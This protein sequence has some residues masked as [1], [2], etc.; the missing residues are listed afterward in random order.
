MPGGHSIPRAGS[1][2]SS[3]K[4]H[5]LGE[6][7]WRR[8]SSTHDIATLAEKG[9]VRDVGN[10]L[11]NVMVGAVLALASGG[12]LMHVLVCFSCFLRS[13]DAESVAYVNVL[14]R[15]AALVPSSLIFVLINWFCVKLFKH[16]S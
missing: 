7:R 15:V 10:D 2:G 3:Q 13:P 9:H 14:Q 12:L 11:R 16:N 5:S 1:S 6:A 8:V 4:E